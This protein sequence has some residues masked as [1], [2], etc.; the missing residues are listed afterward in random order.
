MSYTHRVLNHPRVVRGR[1]GTFAMQM[2]FVAD[3]LPD[4]ERKYHV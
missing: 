1:G 2:F 4:G 3:I